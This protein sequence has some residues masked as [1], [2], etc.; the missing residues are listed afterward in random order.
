MMLRKLALDWSPLRS[1]TSAG[2]GSPR[3]C[4]SSAA[5]S[6]SSP[7]RTR[8]TQLTGSSLEVALLSLAQLVPML[9]PDDRRRGVRRHVRPPP[10]D[11]AAAGRDDRRHILR[12]RQRG[13]AAPQVWPCYAA[14]SSRRPR[15]RS[16]SARENALIPRI[17]GDDQLTAA[18]SLNGV[19]GS[20]GAVVGPA[21]AGALLA[22]RRSP[23]YSS[24]RRRS[25]RRSSRSG[26]CRRSLP[27]GGDGGRASA[28][29]PTASDSCA[30]AR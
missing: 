3:P 22:R 13:A 7:S 9:T 10:A 2:S 18:N 1:P 21:L 6:A 11:A 28:R 24:T 15:T 23:A 4:R 27:E 16:A 25:S 26:C 8:S 29:S 17:V 20:L 12:R 5:R 19:I 14:C 30:A